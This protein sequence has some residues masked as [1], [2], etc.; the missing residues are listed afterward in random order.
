MFHSSRVSE[1]CLVIEVNDVSCD[2][3]DVVTLCNDSLLTEK[4]FR[5]TF[6][7]ILDTDLSAIV[8]LTV[9]KLESSFVVCFI[10]DLIL[11]FYRKHLH[12]YFQP[13]FW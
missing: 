1:S 6:N 8:P 7:K 11:P 5:Y 4:C 3:A 13:Y 2:P 12:P 9:N 10:T